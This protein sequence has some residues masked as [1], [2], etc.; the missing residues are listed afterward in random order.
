[1]WALTWI[2]TSADEV[3]PEVG[4]K[5]KSVRAAVSSRSGAKGVADSPTQ[6]L[7]PAPPSR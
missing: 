7:E 6:G 5:E 4:V 3:S 2:W 1:M